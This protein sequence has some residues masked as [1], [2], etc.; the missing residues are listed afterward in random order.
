MQ[1]RWQKLTDL[2]EAAL[3]MPESA[4]EAWLREACADLDLRREVIEMLEAHEEDSCILDQPAQTYAAD[5]IRDGISLERET[6]LGFVGS[7]RLLELIGSGGMGNVYLGERADGQFKQRVAIKVLRSALSAGHL[8]RRF[9]AERQ[10]LASLDHPSVARILDGGV[11]ESGAPYFVMEYVEGVPIT[12]YCTEHDLPTRRRLELF[13]DVCTAVTNAHR[14]LVVH[15]DLKPSNILVS[16]EG[17]V[18]LLDFGLAK[19][20]EHDLVP[21]DELRTVTGLH[22]MTPEYA[23]PE[24]VMGDPISI[25][26][27]VYQLGILLYELLVGRRP[28]ELASRSITDIAQAVL[29]TEPAKPTDYVRLARDLEA[30][31]LKALRKDPAHRYPSGDHLTADIQRYLEGRPVSAHEGSSA[32]RISRFVR[33]YRWAV[34]ASVLLV[35][36]LAGYAAIITVTQSRTA[37]ERDRA[38][39]YAAFVTGLFKSP[40][41]LA[42]QARIDQPDITVQDFLDQATGRLE[43]DLQDDPEL[44]RDLLVTIGEVY[45][46]L[47]AN[48]KARALLEEALALSN[49]RH[50]PVSAQSLD[51]LRRL[52]WTAQAR[53]E[54][55][56]LY[57]LQLEIAAQVER[58]GGPLTGQS[59]TAYG[60]HL[61]EIGQLSEADSIL[62]LASHPSNRAQDG[63]LP[64]GAIFYRAAVQTD[65]GRHTVADSLL[66]IAYE[67]RVDRYGADHP[68]TALIVHYI[69]IE[70]ERRGELDLAEELKRRAYSIWSERLG[71]GHPMT[72]TGLNDLAVLLNLREKYSEAEEMTRTVVE[73]FEKLYGPDHT[74]TLG[75][76]QSLGSLLL[77]QGRL[78]EAEPY[79]HRAYDGY[80]QAAPNHYR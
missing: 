66:Q 48:D 4:R 27:D 32:Y 57:R 68:K 26:S 61:H 33:R 62:V 9:L 55:D 67:H 23:S 65:L 79:F 16:P 18:K 76:T 8:E 20:L 31:V 39:R 45:S 5:L 41:P 42:S 30:I 59:L 35:T 47:G 50:G 29:K 22:L 44:L 3:A 73:R 25:A 21:G 6:Q 38:E 7:Y 2:F 49:R 71:E 69:A 52:A 74:E 12:T 53:P 40:D 24:Q 28:Y 78:D 43:T 19:V 36:V 51:I 54:A 77:R 1:E 46:N 10:I 80:R 37:R 63:T 11:T 13:L 34:T 64:E 58:G 75:A 56:S 17:H 15:R 70:A 72:V 14:H 60:N